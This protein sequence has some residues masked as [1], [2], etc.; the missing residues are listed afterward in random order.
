MPAVV[1]IANNRARKIQSEYAIRFRMRKQA[2]LTIEKRW[3]ICINKR[4]YWEMEQCKLETRR[5]R[6]AVNT[7]T[8][9]YYII[10]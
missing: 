10:K 7:I 6:T 8:K 9:L 2:A 5:K 1:F 3:K 4:C